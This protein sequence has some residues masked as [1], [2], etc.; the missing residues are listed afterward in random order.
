M[1]VQIIG[2]NG[3]MGK[4]YKAI[5]D[6]LQIPQ[7]EHVDVR[8]GKLDYNAS[9]FII[10]TPTSTHFDILKQLPFEA[11]VLCEKPLALDSKTVEEMLLYANKSKMKFRMVLQYVHQFDEQKIRQMT[12]YL[13]RNIPPMSYYDYFRHGNDGLEWDCLQIVALT[14][15]VPS[16]RETSPIWRCK[17]NG[18]DLDVAKM[19][20]CYC[21]EILQWVMGND[22]IYLDFSTP[23]RSYNCWLI[24]IHRKVE[25]MLC[26]KSQS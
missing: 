22:P 13:A 25:E 20:D 3:S 19:D 4:R 24:D 16:L 9:H 2:C 7:S 17:I 23:K 12:G 5:L 1:R 14:K 21:E 26:Q 15:D 18:V 6:F 8:Q 10:A 11:N